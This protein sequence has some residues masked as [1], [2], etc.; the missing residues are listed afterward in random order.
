MASLST[1]LGVLKTPFEDLTF[2][3]SDSS[4]PYIGKEGIGGCLLSTWR[5]HELH[6]V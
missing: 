6:N 1:T 4:H 2:E 5:A 3:D